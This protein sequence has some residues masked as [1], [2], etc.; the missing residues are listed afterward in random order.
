MKL[1]ELI[2]IAVDNILGSF[3][4]GLK[5]WVLSLAPF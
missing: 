3:F 4:R 1:G 2:D 5:D